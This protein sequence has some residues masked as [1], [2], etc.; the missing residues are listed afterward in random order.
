MA[1]EISEE[2]KKVLETLR[3]L[4]PMPKADNKEDLQRWMRSYLAAQEEGV[5][6]ADGVEDKGRTYISVPQVPRLPV[7]SG[8]KKDCSFDL[9]L[10]EVTCLQERK[11]KDSV[12]W[13]AVQ[14]SL[15]DAAARTAMLLGPKADLASILSKLTSI[16]GDIGGAEAVM[17]ELYNIKQ[18]PDESVSDWSC[19]LEDVV[20]KAKLLGR[21]TADQ[22]DSTLCSRFW[23]GLQPAIKDKTGHKFDAAQDFDE[24]RS[25]IRKF[26]VENAA[27]TKAT[28]KAAQ[29]DPT[30]DLQA[31]VKA[32]AAQVSLLTSKLEKGDTSFNKDSSQQGSAPSYQPRGH[33]SSRGRG[34]RG[35]GRQFI[36]CY[37]CHEFGHIAAECRTDMTFSQSY[38]NGQRLNGP[39]SASRGK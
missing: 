39:G 6:T 16:Y 31:Q 35:R 12:I 38:N 20:N 29:P 9:W 2:E 3:T 15:R 19:R 33:G 18:R 11:Y 26:E 17:T 32:L 36:E 4:G 37:R 5:D 13:E 27:P 21:I 24:L 1:A 14:R 30:A 8:A 28:A 10:Y 34:G 25:A 23:H 22:V 7:F